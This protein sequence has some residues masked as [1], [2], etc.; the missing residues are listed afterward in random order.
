MPT[1]KVLSEQDVEKAL[2]LIAQGSTREAAAK[3]VG[4]HKN[5]LLRYLKATPQW[6]SIRRR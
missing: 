1:E 3:A 2:E 5:T 4:A 6:E